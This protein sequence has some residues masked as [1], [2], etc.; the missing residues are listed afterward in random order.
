MSPFAAAPGKERSQLSTFFTSAVRVL[1]TTLLFTAG[2]MGAGLF[3]GIV[4][5]I[6]YG[7]MKGGNIDMTNAYK[8]VAIPV[9]IT[10]G[11]AAFVGALVQEVRSRRRRTS[12]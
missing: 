10:V 1:F 8:H 11:A 12:R 2:G 5:T 9:A 4:G 7:I 6:V 3:F